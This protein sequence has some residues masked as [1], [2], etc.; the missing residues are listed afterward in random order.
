MEKF[1][2]NAI[3]KKRDRLVTKLRSKDIDNTISGNESVEEA[4]YPGKLGSEGK[5]EFV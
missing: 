5:K 1:K 4:P 3:I 2:D